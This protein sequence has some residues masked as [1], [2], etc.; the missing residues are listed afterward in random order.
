M[1]VNGEISKDEY[2]DQAGKVGT[3]LQKLNEEFPPDSTMAAEL[4]SP[5]RVCRVVPA[6]C[7]RYLERCTIIWQNALTGRTIPCRGNSLERR[8][9]NRLKPFYPSRFRH[10][11]ADQCKCGVPR[12][13]R[14]LVT[15]VK[16]RCPRPTRRWGLLGRTETTLALTPTLA[17]RF[18][19]RDWAAGFVE[20]GRSGLERLQVRDDVV[21]VLGADGVAERGH[22]AAAVGDQRL[23]VGIAHGFAV[24]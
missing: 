21:L 9:W 15:A 20:S 18:L 6:L 13:I 14:T 23:H 4:D 19:T 12:G 2:A 7:S 1:R 16:G 24:H 17:H 3:D 8:I 22:G 5:A 10:A 11:V